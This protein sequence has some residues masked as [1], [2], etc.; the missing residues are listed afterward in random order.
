MLKSQ[1]PHIGIFGKRNVGKSS[2]INTLAAQDVA[3]VS[4][5]P[6]T[7]TD[8][9][10]KTMEITGLGPVVLIDTAGVDDVGDLGKQRVEKTYK[11]I[12]QINL[13]IIV[14]SGNDFSEDEFSLIE[15]LTTLKTPFFV[16]HNKSDLNFCSE[17]LRTKLQTDCGAD[18]LEFSNSILD[19]HQF[20]AIITTI[21]KSLPDSQFNNPTILGD[22]VKYG[23]I[24][25]LVTPIDV[26]AP[27]GRIIQPQV[28]TIRDALDNDCV[29]MMVKERELDLVIKKMGIR[30]NLVVTD[31][32]VFL[33]VDAS[34]PKNIPMTS[35]SIL[36]ARL[37]GEFQAFLQGTRAISKLQQGDRILILES[38]SHHVSCDDIGRVKI[39]RWLEHFTGVKMHY[40]VVSGLAQITR[41]ITDYAIVIQCGG[42]MLTRKQVINK[43]APAI[44][45]GIPVTNYGMCIAYCHG[46]FERAVAPFLGDQSAHEDLL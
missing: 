7:T 46:I 8:P 23:D 26:E 37:K 1:M 22:L 32:Q 28:Q 33:K 30:P 15:Q 21:K 16:V 25:L 19:S 31:S 38:C 11:V 12:K 17:E 2:F 13:A 43:L 27:K 6:G 3:I 9:V 40:D 34:I 24:V 29:V 20:E 35:F 45:H 39:P 18:V 36:F 42:C 41:P 44:E 10:F 14:F 5:Q 4:A